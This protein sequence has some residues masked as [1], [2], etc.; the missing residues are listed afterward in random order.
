MNVVDDGIIFG[1]EID[2]ENC[3]FEIDVMFVGVYVED[4]IMLM[5]LIMF[6]FGLCFDDYS[7]V[8]INFSLS[9]NVLW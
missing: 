9:L 5:D 6:M 8:G 3:L 1:V 4:N 7:K 2:L